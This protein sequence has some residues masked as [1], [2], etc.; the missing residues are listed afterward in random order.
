MDEG[1][2]YTRLMTT[3]SQ[4][5]GG[6]LLL[7]DPD[8]I[9]EKAYLALTE[10]ADKCGVDAILVG[11]SFMLNTNFTSAVK[12]IKGATPLP[13]IVFPGSFA[14]VTPDAD[15]ILFTSL[16]SGRNPN[17]LIDEQV[18]G[19]PLVKR[20]GLEPIPT[21]YMLIESGG[22]TSV[23]YISD[24]SPIPRTKYDIACAHALAAQYLG[25]KFVYLEAGS[26][27]RQPVPLEMVRAVASYVDVPLLVGGGLTSVEE[28]AAR[29]EAGASFIVVGNGLED[30]PNF[31]YLRE[32]TA[33]TH[34]KES[35]TV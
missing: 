26:G 16:I 20:F 12:Q 27:A 9:S 33:A 28:C 25:M 22:L 1:P 14:Q 6:F 11:T 13:V 2:V 5:G 19:A 34:P 7:I 35:V 31:V 15:A 21:G 17:F 18:K 32:L 3:K 4:R 8:K 30:D 29:I 24:T 10:S 23:Q